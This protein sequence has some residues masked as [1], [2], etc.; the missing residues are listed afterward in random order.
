MRLEKLIVQRVDYPLN[1]ELHWHPSYS[2]PVI[3]KG[4]DRETIPEHWK[5]LT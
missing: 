3:P 2:Y 4:I 5:V 1:F